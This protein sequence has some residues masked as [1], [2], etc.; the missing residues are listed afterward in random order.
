MSQ[1]FRMSRR[2]V[3]MPEEVSTNRWFLEQRKLADTFPQFRMVRREGRIAGV[4]GILST[5][6]GNEYGIFIEVS[7][8][9][10]YDCPR[11]FARGWTIRDGCPHRYSPQR[12]CIMQPN[13]WS[14]R[15]TLAFVVAKAA[16]WLNKY[17][18]WCQ[19]GTWPGNQH[20]FSESDVSAL[21]RLVRELFT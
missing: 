2:L 17:E 11:V 16:L 21:G 5:N 14:S 18:V 10:P 20:V 9:Y 13:H 6:L 7:E 3:V 1:R 8:R 12:L 15:F 4:V 19:T